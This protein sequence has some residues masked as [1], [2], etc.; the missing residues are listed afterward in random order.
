MPSQAD[1]QVIMGPPAR[2]GFIASALTG[3]IAKRLY[4]A[5]LR[6]ESGTATIEFCMVLPIV[7]FLVLI[8]LQSTLLMVGNQYVHYSAFAATRSAIVYISQDY[9]DLGEEGRNAIMPVKGRTK[10]DAIR[11]AAYLAVAP[12]CGKRTDS[13]E[14][15]DPEAYLAGLESYFSDYGQDTP[16]WVET[17]A[18]ERLHYAADNTDVYIVE[19]DDN[20]G[21]VEFY[22]IGSEG[23][24]FGPRDPITVRVEHRFNLSVPYVGALFADGEHTDGRGRYALVTAHY[25]LT[26]EGLDPELPDPPS[27]PRIPHN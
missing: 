12:V 7:L 9:S 13:N 10:F 2:G 8:L 18:A 27:L 4:L 14:D 25:T 5:L 3:S 22:D 19:V 20:D 11:S 26:N 21:A 16:R 24:V 17:L 23:H 1:G 6:P 15:V